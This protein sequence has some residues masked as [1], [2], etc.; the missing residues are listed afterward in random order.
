MT[1]KDYS[2]KR[3]IVDS[4]SDP[5]SFENDVTGPRKVHIVKCWVKEFNSMITLLKTADIRFNDRDYAVGDILIEREYDY[6]K[7]MYTGVEFS[8]DITHILP[9][10]M[11]VTQTIDP[12]WVMLSVRNVEV[13]N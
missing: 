5:V 1:N 9:L 2:I 4:G 12:R 7:K 11:F 3:R 13:I 6:D 10:Y 8:C